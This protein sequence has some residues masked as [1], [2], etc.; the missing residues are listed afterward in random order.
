MTATIS[1]THIAEMMVTAKS[2]NNCPASSP[3]NTIG[4][5]TATVVTVEANKAPQTWLV[6]SN[7]ATSGSLPCSRKRTIFSSTTIDASSTM[8]TA[9]AKPASEMTFSVLPVISRTIKLVSKH[10]GIE[11]ATNNVVRR[12]LKNHQSTITARMI[13]IPRFLLSI[14]IDRS[15]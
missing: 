14:S 3:R 13:P 9:K 5:N 2:A 15:I 11:I 1:E 4:R 12:R 7:D 8:P 10:A 6:P